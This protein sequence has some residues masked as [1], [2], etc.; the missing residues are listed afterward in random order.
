MPKQP[1][2]RLIQKLIGFE[3]IA[4]LKPMAIARVAFTLSADTLALA[5][6]S[7]G[8]LVQTPGSFELAFA[9]GAG[10]EIVVPLEI[11]GEQ[12]VVEEFPRAS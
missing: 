7:T 4:D 10:N 6:L 2:S 9:D 8:D 11:I 5:D 3:R 1:G 12:Y